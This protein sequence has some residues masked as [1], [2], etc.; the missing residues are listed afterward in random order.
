MV[1]QQ[2]TLIR[3]NLPNLAIERTWPFPS[4]YDQAGMTGHSLQAAQCCHVGLATPLIC[5]CSADEAKRGVFFRSI[6][7]AL[8]CR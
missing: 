6:R 4:F 3:G 5:Q 2:R 8:S 7:L 1:R